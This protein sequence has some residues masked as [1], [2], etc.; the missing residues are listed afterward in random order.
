[1]T[2]IMTNELNN[3]IVLAS[4]NL[5]G[6]NMNLTKWL[7]WVNPNAVQNSF[8]LPWGTGRLMMFLTNSTYINHA[9]WFESQTHIF[10]DSAVGGFYVPHWWL[11]LNTR[12]QFI[13]VDTAANRIIDYVN[14]NHWEPTL[15][16]TAK[17]AEGADCTGNPSGYSN[18][19]NQWCTNR[20]HNSL[21]PLV[22]T[23][24]VI[25]QIGIGLGLNG[26]TLPDI[27]SFSRDPYAGLDSES[28]IDGFRYNLMGLGPIFAKDQGKVFYKSNLFY[29]PFDPYHPIYI[30]T[31]WQAN[32]PLVHYTIG[33]LVDLS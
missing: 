8:V 31:S 32:D 2:A 5:I 17:L 26:T 9:P 24:G 7:G 3:Q 21:N 6:T 25:N 28:A 18:P 13:L 14:L 33:D 11:N 10:R 29:A 23:V 15:D 22:A 16:I 4:T 12:V 1:M 19:A 20:L 30:H 27:N